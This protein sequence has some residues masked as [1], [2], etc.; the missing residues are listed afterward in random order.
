MSIG[1]LLI[2]GGGEDKDKDPEILQR[3]VDLCSEYSP[4]PALGVVTTASTEGDRAFSTYA[5]AFQRL[6][7]ATVEP[8]NVH[9]RLG[10]AD[11]RLCERL[12][13]VA[14]VFFGGGD[15]LRITSMLGGTP[16]HRA[17]LSR[18][19]DGLVVAGTSAGASMMSSTM[20]V[21]GDARETPTRN[22]VKMAMGMGLWNGAVIDQHFSQRGRISRL[23]SAVAQN[24]EVLGVG[25][26][27]NTAIEVSLDAGT[28]L[29]WG[30]QTV[31]IVDG[32]QI[33][34]TNASESDDDQ[35]LALIGVGLHVL[36][37][38][39]GFNL[40]TRRPSLPGSTT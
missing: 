25:L 8:L 38:G 3:F 13:H 34:E 31:T 18:H 29:V 23:L 32:R 17:L 12:E 36:P 20:I 35:P 2:I 19:R 16:F 27:E 40:T 30:N 24:P 14:G 9:H 33:E 37:R 22:T 4:H 39:F 15:Q 5:R 7:V 26:D 11:E 1:S 28:L 6:G 21:E 10:A